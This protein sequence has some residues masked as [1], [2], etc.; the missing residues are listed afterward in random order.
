MDSNRLDGWKE[1][2]IHLQKD[3]RT[4]QRWEKEYGL[5]VYRVDNHSERAKV[6]SYKSE[7][8]DWLLSK[9][10]SGSFFQRFLAK[11]KNRVF[12]LC[13]SCV[14]LALTVCLIISNLT[15]IQS[16]P[17]RWGVKGAALIVYDNQDTILWQKEVDHPGDLAPYY[18][19]REDNL[20]GQ[21]EDIRYKRSRI[22]MS[23]ID[24]D[25]KMEVVATLKHQNPEHRSVA[26]FDH[27]GDLLW[28]K[29]VRLEQKYKSNT[30]HNDF[31]VNKVG[32]ID[33]EG[34]GREEVAALWMAVGRF[35]SIFLIYDT[36]G[37]ELLRY[38]HTGQLQNYEFS[39]LFEGRR[40]IF[41]VGTNN[42]LDGDAV[43]CVLDCGE[44]KS[45][46]GPPYDIDYKRALKPDD[47]EKYIPFQ[48][49]KASQR[50]YIRFMKTDLSRAL[51]IS[52][53][54]AYRVSAGE[55][56][57]SLSINYDRGDIQPLHFYFGPKFILDKIQPSA[58]FNI[59]YPKL[60]EKGIAKMSKDEFLD[61]LKNNVLFWTGT[62][63]TT[64]PTELN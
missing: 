15:G 20:I 34:D 2:S 51:D 19:D 23:D 50:Y 33:I 5:P 57:I 21:F 60:L 11:R 62:G 32:F 28:E 39:T 7:L 10:K 59:F 1:I 54:W 48:P 63:W 47:L 58:N 64:E 13:T 53:Q 12:L 56:G 49:E 3:V 31:I 29:T 40:Q 42:L 22:D 9:R 8:D 18:E 38:V 45:G 43:L 61:S 41:L 27:D 35:P 4:C 30:L 17:V 24:G 36:K 14:L 44:L 46:V 16:H 52:W 26:L 6:Y 37:T 25:G 55:N